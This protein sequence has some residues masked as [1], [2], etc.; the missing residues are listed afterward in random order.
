MLA[1][2]SPNYAAKWLMARSGSL[3]LGVS[4]PRKLFTYLC[5]PS[6]TY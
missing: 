2:E 5:L 4:P 1:N 6:V 3:G